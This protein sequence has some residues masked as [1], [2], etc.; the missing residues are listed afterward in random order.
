MKNN[1]AIVA[2]G[3]GIVAILGGIILY[4]WA[5]WSECL[6]TGSWWYCLRLLG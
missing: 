3:L 6:T 1:L 4:E 2:M 5:V